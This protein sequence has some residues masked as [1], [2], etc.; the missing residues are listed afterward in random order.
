MNTQWSPKQLDAIFRGEFDDFLI[1]EK[2]TKSMG[3][4]STGSDGGGLELGKS[5]QAL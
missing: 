3:P 5:D 4:S 2:R 1:N